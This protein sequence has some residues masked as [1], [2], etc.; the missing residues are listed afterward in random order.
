MLD[1][2]RWTLTHSLGAAAVL[3][4]PLVLGL[5]LGLVARKETSVAAGVAVVVDAPVDEED[6]E[7][8]VEV[9]GEA[10]FL[11]A[12]L[13]LAVA[14]PAVDDPVGEALAAAEWL[15]DGLAEWLADGLAEWLGD[16]LAEWLADGLAEGER[17]GDEDAEADGDGVEVPDE[18]SA[19]HSVSVLD[20]AA[21][22][23]CAV[24]STP[25]IRKL[26]LSKVTAATLTCAKRMRIA[27]L[28]C[29]SGLPS[30]LW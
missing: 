27:C 5:G 19:W 11:G 13:E 28:R 7:A 2:E 23:A 30:S 20:V 18:G 24:P 26:P 22:A 8:D 14:D 16:G 1:W 4:L 6:A 9:E 25:R 17:D 12:A 3:A 10:V 29:S 15:A 21:G